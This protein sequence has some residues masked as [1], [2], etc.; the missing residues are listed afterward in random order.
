MPSDE[1]VSAEGIVDEYGDRR[2]GCFE[3]RVRSLNDERERY[4]G[5]GFDGLLLPPE[6]ALT[7]GSFCCRAS[8]RVDDDVALQ[9]LHDARMA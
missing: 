5:L 3:A 7:K 6:R 9:R 4:A 1:E 8:Q 2:K